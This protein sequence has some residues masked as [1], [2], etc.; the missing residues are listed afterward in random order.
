MG[1]K[2]PLTVTKVAELT[3]FSRRTITRLFE[4]EPGVL[5]LHRSE[6]M[7]KRGYRNIRIPRT[8][9][10]RVVTRLLVR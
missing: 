9:Y 3:G 2:T 5:I 1:E 7:H 4:K 8:V 6:R 10:E